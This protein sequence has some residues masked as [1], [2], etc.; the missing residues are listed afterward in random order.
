MIPAV[1]WALAAFFYLVL[2][3]FFR[4]VKSRGAYKI[5]KRGPVLFVVGPH[6]NQFIDPMVLVT[7]AGRSVSF[8]MAKKSFDKFWIGLFGRALGAIPV[9]RPQDIV[10]KGVGKLTLDPA[11]AESK[12][13]SGIDT[14]FTQHL[15]T[16]DVLGF[17]G[18]SVEVIEVISDT[19]VSVKAISEN[20]SKALLEAGDAGVAFKITPHVNQNDMFSAV[21]QR[22]DEGECVGIFPEGGSHD[23][24]E[25]LP[26]KAGGAIM[27][28]DAMAKNEYLNVQIVPAG[29][30]Y[31]NAHKW[32]SRAVIEFGDPIQ[33]SRAHVEAYKKG[34]EAKREAISQVLDEI[35]KGMKTVTVTA[36]D[37]DSL[38]LI[39]AARRLYRPIH[40]K[41][42]IDETMYLTRR[43]A[44]IFT[45]FGDD[46]QVKATIEHVA[47]YNRLLK[48]Y[49]I[50][51]HQ[52]M[53]TSFGKRE[54]IGKFALRVAE[55]FFLFAFAAPGA[56]L[57]AP[58]ALLAKKI[59]EKKAAEALRESSVKIEGRDVI[60]TWKVLVSLV[61]APLL[62]VMY[63]IIFFIYLFF[64]SGFT[65]RQCFLSTLVFAVVTV[66][67]GVAAM[68]ASEIGVDV[69]KSLRPLYLSVFADTD[70]LRRVRA[71]LAAEINKT[72][73]DVG[74][75]FYN[76]QEEFE[77][78]RIIRPEDYKLGELL[79]EEM[80]K[81]K[82]KS[83]GSTALTTEWEEVEK[84]E[85]DSP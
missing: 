58:I 20:A 11:L 37:Y 14:L 15:H 76:S 83:R 21:V 53:R 73:T 19:Q 82:S 1:Y 79:T 38:M 65:I 10:K 61:V 22:L 40:M 63:S 6:A 3:I 41:L 77:K 34:G 25:L 48:S 47:A 70:D 9:V 4:E 46:P 18:N 69:I 50:Q 75:R 66:V 44:E 68:R 64:T 24:T 80:N 12:I 30:N 74:P 51:D 62:Y 29:L 52:V 78:S 27:A 55:A 39:Q 81:K 13:V 54:A 67:F 56:L 36:P 60:A 43:F 57:H 31:F 26:L 49:G 59:S 23:R 5:P 72:M 16:R 35:Y 85:A 45:K 2:H 17:S 7:H 8:L 84:S 33:I 32:R 71:E 42:T 28:L